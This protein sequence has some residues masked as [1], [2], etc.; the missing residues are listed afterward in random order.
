[1]T[2]L[3]SNQRAHWASYKHTPQ[4]EQLLVKRLFMI[5]SM[6]CHSR[7][8]QQSN[9]L[10]SVS[11]VYLLGSGVKR[12]FIEVLAGLGVCH[13]YAQGNRLIRTVADNAAV[14]QL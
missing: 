3:L 9:F 10:S 5:T 4:A 12:R 14:R 1:M 2:T 7:A 11:D 13:S 8:K 6:A